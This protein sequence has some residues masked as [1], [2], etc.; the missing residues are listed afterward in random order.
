MGSS[1]SKVFPSSPR[2]NHI[3]RALGTCGIALLCWSLAVTRGA[4]LEDRR[5]APLL[6]VPSASVSSGLPWQGR[7][8]RAVPLPMSHVLRPVTEYTP[9]GNFYGTSEMVGMLQRSAQLIATRWPGSQLAVG[10]LSGPRGGK[11][12]GHRS[13]R[14]G[15]DVDIAFFM[16][17]AA[18]Q[19]APLHGFVA[20]K[21]DGSAGQRE[22]KLYFDDAK[23]WA[24]VA[25]MLRDPEARVQYILVAKRIRARLL[26]EGRR[27]GESEDFLRGAAAV[28]IQPKHHQHAN[29]FHV[30]IYCSADDRPQC[31]DRA[32]FWPWYDGPAR[33]GRVVELPAIHWQTRSVV[34]A[35]PAPAPQHG[36][37]AALAI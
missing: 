18:G 21:G 25:T 34:T 4:A 28:M 31:R 9:S 26:I 27:Q 17:D 6:R 36:D 16:R 24:L 1:S 22:R 14:N 13:H 10:E 33:P 11:L 8:L 5:P 7:L 35:Q 23:N 32:P 19:A 29:H 12:K 37:H 3:A 30:R 20:C 15:R 2:L